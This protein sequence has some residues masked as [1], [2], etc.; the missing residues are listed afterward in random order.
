[1]VENGDS[2]QLDSAEPGSI[3]ITSEDLEMEADIKLKLLATDLG[4]SDPTWEDAR[5]QAVMQDMSKIKVLMGVLDS[6]VETEDQL[7]RM[8][9]K[10]DG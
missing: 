4:C 9:F 7:R 1:M 2:E 5:L 8:Y 6:C 10:T 3:G